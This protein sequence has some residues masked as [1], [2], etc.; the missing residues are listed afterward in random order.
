LRATIIILFSSITLTWLAFVIAPNHAAEGKAISDSGLPIPRFISI[1][2]KNANLRIGP[3]T[4]YPVDWI[5]RRRGVPVLVTA[6][7][8]HWRKVV[9]ADGAEGWLHKSLLSGRRTAVVTNE[10]VNFHLAGNTNAPIIFRAEAGV[11]VRWKLA[12]A[13]GAN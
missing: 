5:Y 6:E 1:S 10:I 8:E 13:T 12:S 7:F 11:M 2:K 4:R 3:G 9:D